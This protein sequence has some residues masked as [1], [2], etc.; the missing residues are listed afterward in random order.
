VDERRDHVELVGWVS[1]TL[2]ALD[3]RQ[4]ADV[5]CGT[6]TGCCTSSQF[7]HI[8]PDEVETIRRIPKALLFPAPRLPEGNLLL[9]YDRRGHCP[10]LRSGVCTI[11]AH[12]PRTCRTYDCRVFPATGTPVLPPTKKP[13]A[14]AIRRW[15]FDIDSPDA[16]SLAVALRQAGTFLRDRSAEL[17][18]SLRP[19]N[20]A[21]AAVMAVLIHD[22]FVDSDPSLD[23]V[24][25]RLQ[26]ARR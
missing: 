5:P 1:D 2:A 8:E 13:I 16:A 21:Q 19:G 22:I 26:S 25:A 18:E 15:T 3:G 10:M 12:R 17:P 14:E 23:Q 11:Y 6:C 24:A 9:G 4:D 20:D 7:I